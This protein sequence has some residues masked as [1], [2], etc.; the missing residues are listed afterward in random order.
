LAFFLRLDIRIEVVDLG[1]ELG[2]LLFE[3]LESGFELVEPAVVRL[4]PLRALGRGS[5]SLH[6]SRPTYS[7]LEHFLDLVF[8]H[9]DLRSDRYD[10]VF[11]VFDVDLD[12]VA[13]GFDFR[14]GFLEQKAAG[15]ETC[16]DALLQS[17]L[18]SQ[19]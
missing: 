1:L 2:F 9:L 6:G 16:S 13:I 12:L 14:D 4:E 18:T 3:L 19:S 11:V 10:A 17:R 15:S 5:W 8:E 7:V